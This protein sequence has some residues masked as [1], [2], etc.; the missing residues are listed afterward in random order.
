MKLVWDRQPD[1]MLSED[2]WIP[3]RGDPWEIRQA[4]LKCFEVWRHG[5]KRP[6]KTFTT[7][8]AAKRYIVK[9]LEV[10]A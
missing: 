5:G 2:V 3:R 7:L 1:F 10:A 6:V 4:G 9:Q 8:E